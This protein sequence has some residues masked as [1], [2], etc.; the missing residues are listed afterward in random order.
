MI[1]DPNLKIAKSIKD[2][3]PKLLLI[4]LDY[5]SRLLVPL[6]KAAELLNILSQSKI[7]TGYGSNV[8]LTDRVPY[9][10]SITSEQ[11]IKENILDSSMNTK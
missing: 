6:E 1:R 7:L 10:F 4:D 5:N 8:D 3:S 11:E 2:N 9:T